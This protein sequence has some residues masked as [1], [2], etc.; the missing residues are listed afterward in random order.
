MSQFIFTKWLKK[1]QRN[2]NE[3]SYNWIIEKPE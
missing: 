1:H 3:L 2:V